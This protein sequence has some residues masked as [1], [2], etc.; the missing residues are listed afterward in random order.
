MNIK[1]ATKRVV[2][3]N[4]LVVHFSD[5]TS[6][7]YDVISL[8]CAW[9]RMSNDEFYNKLGFNFTPH[10]VPGLYEVCRDIVYGVDEQCERSQA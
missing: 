10:E 8:G 1:Y 2:F 6:K 4:T 7:L 5:G 9:F 3:G